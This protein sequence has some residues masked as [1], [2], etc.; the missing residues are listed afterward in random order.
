MDTGP[1]VAYFSDREAHHQWAVE[2]FRKLDLPFI[3]C[4]PV[5]SEACFIAS[6]NGVS[7]ALVLDAV[8]R[9]VMHIGLRV[10]DEL[11]AI[12][13]LMTRYANVPMSLADACLVRLGEM[14]GRPICTLDSDFEI[15]RTRRGRA[16]DLISP[17]R[18]GALHEP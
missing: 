17:P 13:T 16:L 14:T 9:G 4:E 15:Y 12:Q 8:A 5:L 6:R 18:R 1:L 2:Q 11:T 10:E 7:P 3:T